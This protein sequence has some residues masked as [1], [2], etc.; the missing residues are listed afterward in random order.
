[1]GESKRQRIRA[2]EALQRCTGVQTPAGKIQVRWETSSAATP[3][4]QLAYFIEF[5]G[6][7]GLWS[8]WT[9]TCPL[10]YTSPNAP[11][12]ADVLG[13]WMRSILAGHKRYAHVTVIHGDGVNPG[14]LEMNKVISEDAL[15]RALS[16]IPEDKG[17]TWLDRHLSDSV[18]PLLDVPWILD[19]DTTVKP[20]Y[21]LQCVFRSH[22]ATDS[23]SIRPPVPRASGH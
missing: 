20:L 3:M 13:T 10:T 19:I 11:G 4:G 18:I 16:A 9:E 5:L 1:M 22:S 23:M 6:L 8:R 12:I 15:R 7:T 17:V 21:G 2:E 14:L